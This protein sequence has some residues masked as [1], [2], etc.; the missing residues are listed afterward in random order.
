M[1]KAVIILFLLSL[2]LNCVS[3]AVYYIS[4]TGSDSSGVGTSANP[5]ATLTRAFTGMAGGDTLIIRNG[6]YIGTLNAISRN[7]HPPYGT[8]S[9]WTI[10]KAEYDGGAIFDG[11]R[12]L[13]MFNIDYSGT[14]TNMY[15]QFEGIL[16]KD[17]TSGVG[18]SYGNYS[19][20]LRCGNSDGSQG[21]SASFGAGR[22]NYILFENCYAYGS[23]RYKFLIFNSRNCIIRN[24]VARS[25]RINASGEP[26]GGYAIYGAINTEVQNSILIDSNNSQ[27]YLGSGEFIG[28]FGNPVSGA[29]EIFNTNV[30]FR[31]C[32]AVNSHLGG[33]SIDAGHSAEY[34][35]CIWWDVSSPGN[36]LFNFRG[37]NGKVT[38]CTIG[39]VSNSVRGI[40]S[41]DINNC[42]VLNTILYGFGGAGAAA[43]SRSYTPIYR[44]E[45]NSLYNNSLNYIGITGNASDKLTINPIWNAQTNPSGALKY[46]THLESS[47]SLSGQGEGGV[48]IGANV[49]TLIGT[50]G[51]LW[52]EPGYNTDTGVSMWPFPN[53]A[54][55]K[56][57]MAQYFW[58]NSS[59]SINGTKGFAAPGNDLYGGPVTLTSYIWEYLGNPCP[60]DIC[61]YTQTNQTQNQTNQTVYHESD[62]NQNSYIETSEIMSYISRFKLGNV[63][64]TNVLIG[65]RNWLLGRYN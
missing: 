54:L 55:I 34:K 3:A 25:D 17:G 39:E 65:V 63:T 35:N 62:L 23:G 41:Y 64:R 49:N 27:G 20:F 40:N 43:L 30:T 56:S 9:A 12:N 61:N 59:T 37:V 53:E 21:N 52:G 29:A 31:N 8:S 57:K 16:W 60:S 5:W 18:I 33:G 26:M 10:V 42:T 38:S 13:S 19:K 51:T 58:S 28:S 1:K 6:T 7:N 15:I 50:P 4:P 47:S 46:I 11:Q 44:E 32:I 2:S 45:Y 14:S 22:S 24:C 48:D 36:Y